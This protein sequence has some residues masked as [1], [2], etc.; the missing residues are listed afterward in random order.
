MN[1]P[2]N[3]AMRELVGCVMVVSAMLAV[4]INL[5]RAHGVMRVRRRW[6]TRSTA[7]DPGGEETERS[8]VRARRLA[9]DIEKKSGNRNNRGVK[10]HQNV[11][12]P[13]LRRPDSH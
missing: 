1:L 4:L 2:L 9:N 12:W 7:P 8:D 13:A 3:H 5:R 10:C 11:I 6:S